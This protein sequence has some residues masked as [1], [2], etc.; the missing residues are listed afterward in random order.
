[1]DIPICAECH[2]L[3]RGRVYVHDGEIFCSRHCQDE[4]TA[5]LSWPDDRQGE[6]ALQSAQKQTHNV[7]VAQ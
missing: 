1:M 2:H 3:F 5:K 6:L 7:V 4:R